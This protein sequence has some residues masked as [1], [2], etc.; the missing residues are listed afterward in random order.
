MSA[1]PSQARTGMLAGIVFLLLVL[2]L[3]R[4]FGSGSSGA[5]PTG[6]GASDASASLPEQYRKEMEISHHQRQLTSAGPA[7]AGAAARLHEEWAKARQQLVKGK[8]LELA[9]AGFRERVLAEVKEFKFLSAKA[10]AAPP[11]ASPDGSGAAA[12]SPIKVIGLRVE[13]DSDNPD[14]I[15]RLIDRIENMPDARAAVTAV[16]LEGPGFKL[17]PGRLAATIQVQGLALV[18][19]EQP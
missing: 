1:A 3:W 15:Y 8:T 5:T 7:W 18:G 2:V 13:V 9:E 12:S 10:N 6:G 4:Q 16:K 11:P 19:D 14:D 17:E